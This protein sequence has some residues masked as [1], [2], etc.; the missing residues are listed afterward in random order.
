MSEKEIEWGKTWGQIKY[1]KNEIK[2]G[3]ELSDKI[4]K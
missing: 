2:K 3:A 4:E 1:R